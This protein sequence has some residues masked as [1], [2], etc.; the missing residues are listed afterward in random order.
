MSK[1]VA[2]CFKSNCKKIEVCGFM[3]P[4]LSLF[5]PHLREG[6]H[7]G[8]REDEVIEVKSELKTLSKYCPPEEDTNNISTEIVSRMHATN[9]ALVDKFLV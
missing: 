5:L 1:D 9:Y 4:R 3:F 8:K 7:E 2:V 6:G